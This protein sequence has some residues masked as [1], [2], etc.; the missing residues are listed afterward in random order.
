MSGSG[1]RSERNAI[2]FLSGDHETEC[3]SYLPVVSW[4][5]AFEAASTRK[6][7]W[8]RLSLNRAGYDVAGRYQYRVMTI[9]S[10]FMSGSVDG[11]AET[12]AIDLPSGDQ[13]S[14]SPDGKSIAFVSAVPS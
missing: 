14:R 7:C 5:T 1:S 12:N 2:W 10:P 8:W 11:T 4:R 3:S 9:G 13:E 6:R